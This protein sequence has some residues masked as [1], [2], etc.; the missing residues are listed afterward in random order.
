MKNKIAVFLMTLVSIILCATGG[1]AEGFFRDVNITDSYGTEK[2]YYYLG[3]SFSV[4]AQFYSDDTEDYL[5]DIIVALY[6]TDGVLRGV[7]IADKTQQ[8]EYLEASADFIAP[9]EI[10]VYVK[11]YMWKNSNM[12]P[13]ADMSG[14]YIN[15]KIKRD[16]VSID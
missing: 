7:D 12:I 10:E 1:G 8:T 5:A 3:E 2:D 13:V 6:D 16:D 15:G 4:T 14:Y 9:D 11:C